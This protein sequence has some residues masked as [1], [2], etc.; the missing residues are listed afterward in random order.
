MY[1]RFLNEAA[2]VTGSSELG[3]I[4]PL[5]NESETLFSD[6]GRLGVGAATAKDIDER[7]RLASERFEAIVDKELEAFTRLADIS[8]AA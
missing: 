4:A 1:A 8:S 3:E 6:I 7:L 5:L 2:A